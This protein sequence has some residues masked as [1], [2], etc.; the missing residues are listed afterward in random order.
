MFH[1]GFCYIDTMGF[2]SVCFVGWVG[3]GSVDV[4]SRI[5]ASLPNVLCKVVSVLLSIFFILVTCCWMPSSP[6]PSPYLGRVSL[7]F[8]SVVWRL[9]ATLVAAVYDVTVVVIVVVAFCRMSCSW[10][11]WRCCWLNC[12]VRRSEKYLFFYFVVVGKIYWNG[13]CRYESDTTTLFIQR[14][15]NSV[16]NWRLSPW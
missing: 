9:S 13:L 11:P 3:V 16:S 14:T 8:Y 6:S 2:V 10:S 12:S 4:L 1:L 5:L 15:H 7:S